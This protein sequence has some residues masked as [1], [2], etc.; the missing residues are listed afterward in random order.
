MKKLSELILLAKNVLAHFGFFLLGVIPGLLLRQNKNF[1]LLVFKNSV[2]LE[3]TF[4]FS[5]T[6]NYVVC[7]AIENRVA[8]KRI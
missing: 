5:F 2:D 7:S 8:K 3:Q 6:D 1:L 4:V